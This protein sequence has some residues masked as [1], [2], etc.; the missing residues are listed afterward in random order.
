MARE[1]VSTPVT[2]PISDEL[3]FN[4]E[5]PV[6][7]F[8]VNLPAGQG[9]LPRG[10]ALSLEADGTHKKLGTG[11]GK[12]N[13]ILADEADTTD[14][15]VYA[16]AYRQGHFNRTVVNAATGAALT[17]ANTEDLRAVSVMLSD[18]H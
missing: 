1:L 11:A 6:L 12:A 5:P 16:A 13:A 18:A 17:A 3:I 14:D 10:T 8:G 7:A 15:A 4:L 9:V 2:P